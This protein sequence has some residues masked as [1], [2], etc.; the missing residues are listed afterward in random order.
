MRDNT[1]ETSIREV[2]ASVV[3]TVTAWPGVSAGPHRF[4]GV[5][6]TLGRRELGHIHEGGAPIADLPFPRRVRDELLA[7]GRVRRH[8]VLPDSGWATAP[9]RSADDVANVIDL[10]RLNYDRAWRARERM[11][12]AAG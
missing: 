3:D 9:L 10:F 11:A 1:A 7:E 8:Y 2:V 12:L 4:A 6:L 5:E